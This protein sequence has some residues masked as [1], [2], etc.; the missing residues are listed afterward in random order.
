MKQAVLSW[1][2]ETSSRAALILHCPLFQTLKCD[3]N[4]LRKLCFGICSRMRAS[5]SGFCDH[6]SYLLMLSQA[7]CMAHLVAVHLESTPGIRSPR[8]LTVH[9]DAGVHLFPRQS[10]PKGTQASI[11]EICKPATLLPRIRG[12]FETCYVRGARTM[13]ESCGY[14]A[15]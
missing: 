2:S 13:R 3:V 1:C 8:L 10:L 6:F 14:V 9:L 11:R 15:R 7:Q 12:D 4:S 5:R